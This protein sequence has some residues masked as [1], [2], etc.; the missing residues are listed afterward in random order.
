MNDDLLWET[1][2]RAELNTRW[3]GQAYHY[4]PELGSTNDQLKQ[5]A[6]A[7]T[8]SAPPHGTILLTDFQSQ[9]R[10]RLNRR[11]EA[12]VD[13]SLLMSVLFRP[14]WP[15]ERANW[16][17]M[18]V[19]LAV[20]EVVEAETAVRTGI[21]WPND[22]MVWQDGGWRKVGGLLLEA[23]MAANGRLAWAVVGVGINVNMTADQL[24]PAHTTP[25]SLQLAAGRPIARRALL[26]AILTRM[27]AW[28]ETAVNGQSPHLPW[29]DRLITLHQPVTVTHAYSGVQL[30][31]IAEAT[32]ADGAL[33]VRDAQHVVHPV[34]AGDVTL[35]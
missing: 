32:R 21:K 8:E 22:I 26:M 1:A 11:W 12:P 15:A 23:D 33:L 27:E 24:P 31:G 28:Y 9:G 7:G 10:G 34:L 16:L 19:S 18:L 17:T 30:T 13:S 2:V 6:R 35:R 25:S 4:F 29:Q 3:L 5:M 14:D 20:A